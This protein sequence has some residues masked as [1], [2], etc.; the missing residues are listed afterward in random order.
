MDGTAIRNHVTTLAACSKHG[1]ALF[2]NIDAWTSSFSPLPGHM[3]QDLTRVWEPES[4]L[5]LPR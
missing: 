5:N 4:F 3:N 1:G 2:K